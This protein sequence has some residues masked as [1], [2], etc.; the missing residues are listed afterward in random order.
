MKK[1]FILD[2]VNYLF[3]SY[4]A[5]GPMT[6]EKGQSTSALYGFIRSVQK[7]I[8]DF[9]PTHLVVVFDGPDNKK[10]RQAVY[11]EYKMHRKGAPEDLFPQFEW[12]AEFCELAGLPTLCVE[13]VEADDTMASVAAWAKKS[14]DVLLCT[15]DKD[16]CQM[17]DDR[18]RI[19]NVHKENLLVDAEKVK[20]L[21]SVRP[22]QM[23]D[24]LAIMGDAS[25]NI[26]GLE[27]FGPK[28]ASALLQEFGTLDE[29]LAH[30]EK[31]KGEK[32]QQIL[33]DQKEVALMSRQL[34]TLDMAIDIP[35]EDEF[36]RLKSPDTQ[37][38]AAFYR[39]MNFNTLLR[40]LG[41]IELPKKRGVRHTD[42][43]DY[44]LIDQEEDL[45][46]LLNKLIQEKEICIDTE[47]TSE[48]PMLA[49]LVGVGFCITPGQ[50]W[51]VPCNGKLGK[52]RVLKALQTLFAQCK[53]FFYGHNL[54]YDWHVLQNESIELAPIGFDTMVASY[55]LNPQRRRHN[56]DDLTL[57]IFRKVKIPIETLLG[58]G[59]QKRTMQD[60]PILEVKE[61]CCED[62]DYTAR[63]KEQFLEELQERNLDKLFSTAT[64]P[65]SL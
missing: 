2:A 23:L 52:T 10:S 62:V 7:L 18:V 58:K 60:V 1:L 20:E 14:S 61:Y 51:Y 34:A 53:G 46:E 56:L 6:N 12:A 28:T 32:K 26:P 40:D 39:K 3:R 27:G 54:K 24:Y 42:R 8:K 45:Q 9:E 29:I 44:H 55:V 11:A 22:D 65:N 38:L 25:D 57:E 19:I 43:R 36:Y 17:V 48:K 31:V 41:E 35:K 64:Q 47:T 59:K 33:R 37:N 50:A 49:E 15:S 30:P 16:L 5:I 21:Y 13:G 63:L 4:Y